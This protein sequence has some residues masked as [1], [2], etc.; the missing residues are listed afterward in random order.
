MSHHSSSNRTRVGTN[1]LVQLLGQWSGGPGPLYRQLADRLAS[2]IA[3]GSLHAHEL[4]PPERSLAPALKLSRGTIVR[5][6]DDLA[7]AAVVSR[8][9][10]SG[11]A[12]A[13]RA[14]GSGARS[15]QFVGDHLWRNGEASIDLLKAMP[16]M[17]PEVVQL[18]ADIDL[19]RHSSELDGA[20][21]L[22]WWGLRGTNCRHAHGAGSPDDSPP[23]PRHNRCA[24]R[25]FAR[26]DG[27][28]TAW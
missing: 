26:R 10:G 11:T 5:A 27:D 12:V 6:Y 2:L 1:Q 3:D 22:G 24:A 8:I 19:S 25:N 23:G 18:V 4:L 13:G 7:A 21:P 20:E 17:L 16:T 15:A 14:L 9:R 28:G